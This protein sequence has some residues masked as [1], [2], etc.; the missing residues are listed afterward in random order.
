MFKSIPSLPGKPARR[1]FFY[2]FKS[3]KTRE[4]DP[5]CIIQRCDHNVSK[6]VKNNEYF[7]FFGY[8][9]MDAFTIR[10][11]ECYKISE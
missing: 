9:S 11:G 4:S 3:R 7:I 8:S 10:I 2:I 1:V 6:S 5:F